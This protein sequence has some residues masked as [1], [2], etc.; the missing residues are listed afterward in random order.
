MLHG[1][2]GRRMDLVW[3]IAKLPPAEF[4]RSARRVLC[5]NKA[6]TS[7]RKGVEHALL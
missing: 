1:T 7:R 4:G 3:G 6:R 2:G 5:Q